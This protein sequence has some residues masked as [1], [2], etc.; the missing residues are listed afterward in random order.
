MA[1]S[2]IIPP[3]NA[4]TDTFQLANDGNKAV[5]TMKGNGCSLGIVRYTNRGA[6]C[7]IDYWSN[8]IYVIG[9][10]SDSIVI[11]KDEESKVIT[12]QNNSSTTVM[13]IATGAT[14]DA[15]TGTET[16]TETVTRM[17][18]GPAIPVGVTSGGTGATSTANARVNLGLTY[19]ANDTYSESSTAL[20]GIIRNGST[21][22]MLR[23]TLPKSMENVTPSV[24]ALTGWIASKDGFIASSGNDT[25]WISMSGATVTA[26][27]KSNNTVMIVIDTDSVLTNAVN[28]I[29]A[30]YVS[31]TLTFA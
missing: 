17:N 28:G 2:T 29:C 23:V 3:N 12:I 30:A 4:P 15:G 27:K 16:I 21:K 22:Y 31:F 24:T 10:L 25:N 8:Y 14:I 26:T 11:Q 18:Y 7:L 20:D 1:T 9:V 5:V 13:L 6:M 19:A